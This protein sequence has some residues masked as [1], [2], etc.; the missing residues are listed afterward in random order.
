MKKLVLFFSLLI[1]NFSFASQDTPCF[2]T[3]DEDNDNRKSDYVY[4]EADIL[5]DSQ[6]RQLEVKLLAFEKSSANQILIVTVSDLCKME[7]SQFATKIGHDFKVGQD[8]F[9][10]GLVLLIHPNATKGKSRTFIATGYG[11]EGAIPDITAKVIVDNELIPN[12]K[13]GQFFKGINEGLNVLIS[14]TEG[15]YSAQEYSKK[16][17]KKESSQFLIFIAIFLLIIIIS[18]SISLYNAKQY[19]T[20]N[21]IGLW[22]AYTLLQAT[23]RSHQGSYRGG[24]SV[25]GGGYSGGGSSSSGGGFGGFG[26]GSF[27]GGGAGG[28]W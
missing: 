6:E 4:D 5:T 23:R 1:L 25:G 17:D 21:N 13:Q 19:A 9:D 3:L 20:V 22:E 12:F 10:N 15:E 26:G 7:P 16:V 8:K 24:S 2:P 11:L 18:F 27:G 28:S 14:L